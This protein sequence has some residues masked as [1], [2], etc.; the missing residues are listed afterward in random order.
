MEILKNLWY[1]QFCQNIGLNFEVNE[2][3]NSFS[4][5]QIQ[6]LGIT[7]AILKRPEILIL[8]EVK[9]IRQ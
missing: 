4:G 8:D 6:R 9:V 3:G 2:G 7:R 1:V 5:G